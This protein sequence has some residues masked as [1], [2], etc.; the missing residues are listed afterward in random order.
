MPLPIILLGLGAAAAGIAG[1]KKVYNA[2]T[3]N[4]EADEI[5][6][7]A[8]AIFEQAK[9]EM[10]KAKEDT[11]SVL[12][13]LGKIKLEI[14]ARQIGRF[15]NIFS[16]IRNVE[17]MGG[18]IEN[19]LGSLDITPSELLEM[20]DLSL[21][22]AEIMTGGLVST[23][24]GALAGVASYGGAM[25]LAS[26]S[27]GTAIS[28]LSGAAATNATLAWFGGGSLAAGGLGMAGGMVVLGGIC[29]APA[30]LVGG[31]LW[32]A[33]ARTN[34]VNAQ[35]TMA[36]A[37]K[38]VEKM[39][40]AKTI[41]QSIRKVALEFQDLINKTDSL[42]TKALDKLEFG[43]GFGTDYNQFKEPQR[44]LVHLNVQ[45][46]QVMKLL[47]ET[48]IL[49]PDGSLSQDYLPVLEEGYKLLESVK[50]KF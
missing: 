42:M 35:S 21:K 3:T 15:I 5:F 41:L 1:L 12:V 13:Q 39:N 8:Q 29:L 10:N 4:S 2:Y 33:K 23:G 11:N 25:M 43:I 45:F 44:Q 46:A 28:A 14:W 19:K 26:A 49:K 6:K 47:L 17:V 30:L 50:N 48:P 34:Y 36:Q 22:A 16:Q 20:R 32:N 31:M 18:P 24:A 27:T 7:K 37:E 40:S 9:E 38:E